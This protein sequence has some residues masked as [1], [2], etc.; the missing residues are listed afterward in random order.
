[1]DYTN[2]YLWPWV[3]VTKVGAFVGTFIHKLG[4]IGIMAI[5]AILGASYPVLSTIN[6][7]SVIIRYQL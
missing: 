4:M 1:M 7:P 5:A 6:R 3:E 2:E